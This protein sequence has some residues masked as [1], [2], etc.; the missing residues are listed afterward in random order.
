MPTSPLSCSSVRPKWV[1]F[2]PQRMSEVETFFSVFGSSCTGRLDCGYVEETQEVFSRGSGGVTRRGPGR[3]RTGVTTLVGRIVGTGTLRESPRQRRR[4][5]G[6]G[7][8]GRV[9]GPGPHPGRDGS[10]VRSRRGRGPLGR[11]GRDDGSVRRDRPVHPYT[12]PSSS[13]APDPPKHP[14]PVP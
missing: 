9:W 2:G 4:S 14:H 1:S 7:S 8:R 6:S 11:S 12:D 5:L 3:G 13:P 10:E